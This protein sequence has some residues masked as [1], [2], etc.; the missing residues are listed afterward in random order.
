MTEPSYVVVTEAPLMGYMQDYAVLP[1]NY[2][3]K[4]Y[5][6]R[7]DIKAIYATVH[8]NLDELD[9]KTGFTRQIQNRR[10]LI[11]PNLVFVFNQ[12]GFKDRNYP[13]STDPRVFDAIIAYLVRYTRDIV[14]I[15][16]SGEGMPTNLSFQLSGLDRIARRY[17]IRCRALELEP[18]VRYMLPQAEV[19]KEIYIP[20]ILDEVVKGQ[21]FYI[22]VPKMKTNL[23]TGVTLGFKNA[24]GTIPYK[25]RQRNHTYLIN[26]KLVDML[27]LFKPDLTIIDGIVGGEGNTPAPV[28]PVDTRVIISGNNSVE[29]DRVTTRMMGID[30]DAN[31]LLQ[32]AVKKGFNDPAVTIIGEQKIVPF[33]KANNSIMDDEFHHDFPNVKVLVGFHMKHA[34]VISDPN[35]VSAQTARQLEQV[36]D[37]G[38]LACSKTTFELMKYTP[39][40]DRSFEFAL[41]MGNGT[42]IDGKTYYFDR[43]GKPYTIE[44]IK[45]LPIRKATLGSCTAELKPFCEVNGEGCC[46]PNNCTATIFKASGQNLALQSPRNKHF[47]KL[48]IETMRVK[49]AREKMIQSGQWIDCPYE[50]EDKIYELPELSE[51]DRQERFI[52]WPL[53]PMTAEQKAKALADM[54]V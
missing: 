5:F 29:V 3:T 24:M 44:D 46:F 18:V 36:C 21:A 30:P 52:P 22:S 13:E 48:I 9:A 33:R 2:G 34:P 7:A 47:V 11:K 17:G 39:D 20:R 6:D 40:F 53:A 45:A 50:Q 23:F 43:D 31:K 54:K 27:Y 35:T 41:I 42:L 1:R 14:I 15:E 26:K 8:N 49:W 12:M 28:D 37:G 4:E 10:I 51:S 38:C 19:M 16:S 25:L 32:E